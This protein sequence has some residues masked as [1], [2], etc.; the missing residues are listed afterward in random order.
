[1]WRETLNRARE[2]LH[3]LAAVPAAYTPDVEGAT[4][5]PCAVRV[6]RYGFRAGDVKGTNYDFAERHEAGFRIIFL[7]AEIEPVRGAVVAVEA[8]ESYCLEAIYP[9]D[10]ITVAADAIL[11][12]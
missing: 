1:M 6:H 12:A 7:A 5:T 10:G 2:T 3:R 9:R 8:G 4:A 11:I